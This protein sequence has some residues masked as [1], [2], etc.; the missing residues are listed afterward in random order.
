MTVKKN[1]TSTLESNDDTESGMI[2][3]GEKV[4][5]QTALMAI[6]GNDSIVTTRALFDTGSTRSYVTEEVANSLKFKPIEE[7]TFSIYAFGDT[8]PKQKTAS[9]VELK[10][11]TRFGKSI[12]IKATVTK[13]ISGPLLRTP[14][15]LKNQRMLMQQYDL[16]D[17]LPSQMETY[18]LGILIGNDHYYDIML[19]KREVVQENLY[20]LESKL[21]WILSGRTTIRESQDENIL[22]LLSTSSDIPS[23][24]H[25]MKRE[26]QIAMFKP[27]VEDLWNLENIG[28]KPK[29]KGERDDFVMDWFKGT[30]SRK[31]KR[32][33]VSWPWR[34]ENE[35]HL[36]ENFELSLGR[37]KSLIKRL[38]KN[39]DLLEKYINIIQ[40]Q[41]AKGIIERV[42][43]SEE[44]NE[45]RK[46][47]I[48][49]HAV[50]TPK[51]T[52]TKIRI[53]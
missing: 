4:I 1:D 48:P 11:Q 24:L 14:L 19:D 17:T 13:Q 36:P 53:V 10:I 49:H 29:E 16:A 46:H 21:G 6:K 30:V 3:I 39:P 25:K 44:D 37:L 51:K 52:T 12:K 41:I 33:F 35:S 22:F 5:M 38:E 15:Q 26:N 34:E 20:V 28:I 2:A 50:I 8:K 32:Y 47:Y 31:D 42:E 45:N 40:E 23:E 43:S 18:T 7:Q 9:I 27:N